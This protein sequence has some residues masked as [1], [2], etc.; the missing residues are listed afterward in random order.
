MLLWGDYQHSCAKLGHGGWYLKTNLGPHQLQPDPAWLKRTHTCLRWFQLCSTVLICIKS[1]ARVSKH[2][3]PVQLN[4]GFLW[5][6]AS[7]SR[8][9][10]GASRLRGKLPLNMLNKLVR[11]P[12]KRAQSI[13]PSLQAASAFQ[14]KSPDVLLRHPQKKPAG[15]VFCLLKTWS[16]NKSFPLF[17]L[18]HAHSDASWLG[19][20]SGVRPERASRHIKNTWFWWTLVG[21][22]IRAYTYL[23]FCVWRLAWY[24]RER[25]CQMDP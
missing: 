19:R 10:Y 24:L 13:F 2:L 15:H 3:L 12:Q 21:W 22:V 23:N 14:P 1:K 20:E 18:S 11:L 7:V 16:E 25:K 9:P 17:S 8:L 5:R 4:G 6:R